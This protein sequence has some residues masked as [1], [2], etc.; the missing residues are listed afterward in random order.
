MG[1]WVDGSTGMSQCGRMSKEVSK[2]L[3]VSRWVD[4]IDGL[5]YL[6]SL[7]G[8]STYLFTCLSV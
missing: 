6:D 3:Y 8:K 4:R 7:G 2:C 1:W 5:E